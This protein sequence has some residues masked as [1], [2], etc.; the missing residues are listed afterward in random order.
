[1][2]SYLIRIYRRD[3]DNPEG[4]V[5]IIE[6]IGAEKRYSFRNISELAKIITLQKGLNERKEI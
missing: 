1:M 2:D 3:K 6:E 4:I 5:G